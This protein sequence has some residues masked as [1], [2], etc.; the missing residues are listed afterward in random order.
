MTVAAQAGDATAL[1]VF[2]PVG[3]RLGVGLASFANIF[4]PEVIVIGGG[5]MAAGDLLLD[6]V[7]SSAT[8]PCHR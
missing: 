1:W 7:R 5:V 3:S 4:E 2:E 8:A 6:R